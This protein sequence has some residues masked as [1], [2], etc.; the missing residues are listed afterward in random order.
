MD[1]RIRD[2]IET[3]LKDAGGQYV[4]VHV[5]EASSSTIR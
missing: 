1:E 3:A 2:R 5:E 4:E